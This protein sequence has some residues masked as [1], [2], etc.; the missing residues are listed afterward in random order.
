ML[1]TKFQGQRP[2]GYR[3]EDVFNKLGSQN[4]K[5]SMLYTKFQGHWTLS[6]RE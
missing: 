4:L 5:Y 1:H 3:E 2:F 6:S